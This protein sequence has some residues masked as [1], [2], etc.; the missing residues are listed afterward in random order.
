VQFCF[1]GREWLA[2]QLDAAGIEYRRADNC[3]LSLADAERA[4]AIMD[5]MVSLP[6]RRVL[7]GFVSTVSPV[8]DL[9]AEHTGGSYHWTLH[10]CEF[11]TDVM[12]KSPQALAE[13]YPSLAKFAI[14]DLASSDVMRYLGKPT[15]ETYRGE[16]VS[17]Y[18]IRHEGI[19]VRHHVGGNSIKVYDKQ[20]SVLRVETTTN[21]PSE[22][23][24]RRHA[25]GDPESEVKPRPMRKGIADIKPRVRVS[26][27]AN[28]CYLDALATVD[29]DRTVADALARVLE[30]AAIGERLVR[31][32]RPWTD[33]DLALLRAVGNGDF[34]TNGFRS[35]D[36]PAQLGQPLP[37]D[38]VQRTKFMAKLSR[39]LR[40]LRAHG[41]IEKL[42]GT[43][44]YRVTRSGRAL[45]TAVLA[46]LDASIT[47]L[48]Q[49]A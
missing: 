47:K 46:A 45:I 25:D 10:Q 22:F 7:D 21:K 11:A 33:P 44:R 15:I 34:I 23:K 32:L 29:C 8:L 39:H 40:L 5:Q 3:F 18:K 4:Q 36:I 41:V 35:R 37:T 12:F 13:L 31:A 17:N 24:S 38:P 6:W 1:N 20:G 26:A 2:R 49:C 14:T 43:H 16:V 9:I 42:Q 28:D 48:K 27:K 30:R 19:C